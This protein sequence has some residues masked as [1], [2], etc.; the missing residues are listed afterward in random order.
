MAERF[1]ENKGQF[2]FS[3]RCWLV[4]IDIDLLEIVFIDTFVTWFTYKFT[5][6]SFLAVVKLRK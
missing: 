3:R 5:H 1:P 2:I 4:F 6:I